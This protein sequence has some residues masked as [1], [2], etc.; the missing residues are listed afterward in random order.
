MFSE[1][2]Q[3][4]LVQVTKL[5]PQRTYNKVI[6]DN[7]KY[8]PTYEDTIIVKLKDSQHDCV[9][10]NNRLYCSKCDSSI[11]IRAQHIN[12]FISSSCLQHNIWCRQST[13]TALDPCFGISAMC[14]T[15]SLRGGPMV[16]QH[17]RPVRGCSWCYTL[18]IEQ[19]GINKIYIHTIPIEWFYT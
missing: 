1:K 3:N 8:K 5:F 12:T 7:I 6:L 18:S 15:K 10:H 11:A 17:D 9:I 19:C 16:D 4:R 2:I 13:Y 14:T